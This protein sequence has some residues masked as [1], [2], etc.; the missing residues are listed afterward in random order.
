MTNKK[1]INSQIDSFLSSNDD[2][3]N[4][5]NATDKVLTGVLPGEETLLLAKKVAFE[6]VAISDDYNTMKEAGMFESG[7]IILF[8]G[9]GAFSTF[10]QK[11]TD[12]KISHVGLVLKID[13]NLFLWESFYGTDNLV[14]K[15][16]GTPKLSGSRLVSLDDRVTKYKEHALYLRKLVRPASVSEA[17]ISA[18]IYKVVTTFDFEY[19]F[20]PS[21]FL[22]ALERTWCRCTLFRA[23]ANPQLLKP[24][25]VIKKKN[26]TVTYP[27]SVDTLHE[28]HKVTLTRTMSTDDVFSVTVKDKSLYC[29]ALVAFTFFAC[30]IWED[31]KRSFLHHEHEW[32]YLPRD[33]YYIPSDTGE[34]RSLPWSAGFSLENSLYPIRVYSREYAES[35]V[36]ND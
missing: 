20:T 1:S 35:I 8:Y 22:E 15:R 16:F 29:S 18:L 25:L 28:L 17:Q 31:T 11:M 24:N 26:E 5:S 34:Y 23:K 4:Q 33:Y 10:I 9:N 21:H 12:C 7:D 2:P 30:G 32:T 19:D 14:D 3:R 6:N 36:Y 13:G 27:N